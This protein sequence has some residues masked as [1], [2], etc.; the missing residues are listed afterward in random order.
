MIA[1]IVVGTVIFIVEMVPATAEAGARQS[2]LV[3]HSQGLQTEVGQMN[4]VKPSR[5]PVEM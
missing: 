2:W 1:I 3:C 5:H 4:L